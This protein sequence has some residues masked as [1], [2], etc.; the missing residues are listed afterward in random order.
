MKILRIKPYAGYDWQTR[1][2]VE[3]YTVWIELDTGEIEQR[4]VN[5]LT[6]LEAAE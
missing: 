2:S 3:Y 4:Q 5:D 6:E 1:Q